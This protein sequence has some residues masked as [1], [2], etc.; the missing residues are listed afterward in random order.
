M[1]STSTTS[2]NSFTHILSKA[3]S[4]HHQRVKC[5][6]A[7]T[8]APGPA[9]ETMHKYFAQS[10]LD[11]LGS[12]NGNDILEMVLVEATGREAKALTKKHG[13]DSD[14]GLLE[15]K[16]L[17]TKYSAHISDDTPASLLRHQTIPYIIIGEASADGRVIQW[18]ISMSYRA[19]DN[20]RYKK[21]L[22]LLSP[23]EHATA[24]DN[25]SAA[26]FP[27]ELPASA[28]A[29]SAVLE[30]LK[31]IWK[32]KNYIR[33]NPLPIEDIRALHNGEFSLWLNREIDPK[34]LNKD[35]VKLNETYPESTLSVEYMAPHLALRE[36][37]MGQMAAAK[38]TA[39]A[40]A[41]QAAEEKKNKTA[42][43]EAK[44]LQVAEEKKIK[45]AEK[46]VQKEAK[47]AEKLAQKEAKA[48]KKSTKQI[49]EQQSTEQQSTE[50]QSTKQST[51]QSADVQPKKI[52]LE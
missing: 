49:T 34:L 19:F 35:I 10:W 22:G 52:E 42:Q 41:L 31:A 47:A 38:E 24:N 5:A 28:D 2:L 39:E 33:A 26:G 44:A 32:P 13:A 1:Q 43:K 3:I 7:A 9:E 27:D 48:A 20:S 6:L 23:L 36:F 37:C 18:A 16:P 29:R 4:E 17:K 8:L 15:S 30:R 12:K 46:L 40:K 45:A 50:Q 25:A 11:T 14:D 21:M 51:E